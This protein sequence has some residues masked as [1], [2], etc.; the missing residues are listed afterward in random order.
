M[1]LHLGSPSG[2]QRALPREKRH[3]H[4]SLHMEL[5]SVPGFILQLCVNRLEH[6]V[7]GADGQ[8]I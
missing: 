5:I 8:I 2:P 3:K 4:L 1:D 6:L 7:W